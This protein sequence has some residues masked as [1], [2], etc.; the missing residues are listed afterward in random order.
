MKNYI[1]VVV[2]EVNL[3][4]NCTC[5]DGDMPCPTHHIVISKRKDVP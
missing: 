2:I 1:G 4:G 3:C 5:N